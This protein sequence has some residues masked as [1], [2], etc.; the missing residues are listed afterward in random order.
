MS[1]DPS[2][3]GSQSAP[4]VTPDAPPDVAP[5]V[6]SSAQRTLLRSA[7]DVIIPAKGALPAA[8]DVDVATSIEHTLAASPALRRLFLDGLTQLA[9]A[10]PDFVSLDHQ[11]QTKALQALECKQP[12]F[13]TALV[14]HTYRGYYVLPRVQRAL[15]LPG[16]PPQPLGYELPDFD[17]ALL[18]KQRQRA[19]FWRRTPSD[20]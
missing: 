8:G 5:T 14:E 7:L 9:I 2:I 3:A 20:T 17:P 10:S 1:I 11:T 6:L 4:A 13:F 18:D 15:G 12:A 16:R 19:P